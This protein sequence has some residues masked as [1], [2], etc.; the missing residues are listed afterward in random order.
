MVYL[1]RRKVAANYQ[2]I[3]FKKAKTENQEIIN[4]K[5]NMLFY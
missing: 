3:N 5:E 2:F 1:P 4:I